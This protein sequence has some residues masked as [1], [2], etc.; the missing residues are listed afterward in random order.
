VLSRIQSSLRENVRAGA[1]TQVGPFLIRFDADTDHPFRNYA[2]P[3]DGARPTAAE[4]AELVAAFVD[5]QR[6]PRLEYLAPLPAVDAALAAAGFTVDVRLP[7]LVLDELQAPATP[8]DVRMQAVSTENEL[9]EAAL[10]QNIAYEGRPVAD[11]DVRRLQ[12]TVAR[13]GTVVLAWH[14]STPAGSGL[15]TAPQDGLVQLAAIG[16]RPE[17]RR[18]GIAS[19]VTAELSRLALAAGHTPYLEAESHNEQRLYQP[20]G[21]RTIGEMIA[22]SR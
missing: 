7:L 4:V 22:I 10:V 9:R 6:K 1:A 15:H 21:Y 13:G 3:D 18:R 20:L 17:F 14:G 11:A 8:A 16:V 19:A 2:I 12:G 5:R